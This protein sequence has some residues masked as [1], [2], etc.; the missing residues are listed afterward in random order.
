MEEIVGLDPAP[1]A[2]FCVSGIGAW[3]ALKFCA[4][5]K[6]EVPG[7]LSVIGVDNLIGSDMLFPPLTTLSFDH[8]LLARPVV[9]LLWGQDLKPRHVTVRPELVLRASTGPVPRDRS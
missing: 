9:E 4:E 3:A 5:R 6:I 1:T 8:N 7:K 2:L